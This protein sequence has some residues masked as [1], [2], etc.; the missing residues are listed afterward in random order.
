MRSDAGLG[1]AAWSG[2][3]AR[4]RS[5]TGAFHFDCTGLLEQVPGTRGAGSLQ[6]A[7]KPKRVSSCWPS[8]ERTKAMN[9]AAAGACGAFFTAAI[10]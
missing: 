2:R 10:G 5:G 8:A 7:K 9:A 6:R 3:L 1:G 4:A